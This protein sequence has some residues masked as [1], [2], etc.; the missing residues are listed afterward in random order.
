M[1]STYKDDHHQPLLDSTSPIPVQESH[2]VFHLRGDR[3]LRINKLT[4]N[5]FLTIITVLTSV[6]MNVTLPLYSNSMTKDGGSE[7]P[8]LLLS[9]M[10]FPFFFFGLVFL[11][12]FLSPSMSLRSSVSNRIMLLVG[13]LNAINGVLVVYASSTSRTPA[14]LQ[15]ILSTSVI[16]FTVI[17][18]Y[19]LLR[20]G[21]SKARLVCTG[22]V[23]IGL[24]I[25]LEP[26]IFN[27]DGNGG[28]G[29]GGE[30]LSNFEK[31]IWPVIFMF[32][33]LPVGI[34]NAVLERELKKGE[35]ESLLFLAWA[36]LYNFVFIAALF[37]TD[38][39]PRF[40]ASSSFHDFW[41][42]LTYGLKCQYGADQ[43]CHSA[44]GASWIFIL[45]YCSANLMIFLLVKY[46]E[47]AIYLVVV[48]AMVTPLGALF[49][50]F[51]VPTPYFHWDPHFLQL[52]TFFIMLGILIMVPAVAMYNYFGMKEEKDLKRQLDLQS[53]DD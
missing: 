53:E 52:S 44:V 41:E 35:T 18:R 40:G 16:P 22:I 47:G 17:S 30:H 50:T 27:I 15:A 3:I 45:G 13:F 4:W 31:F 37:W 28:G 5:V 25:S 10:W 49:W 12:K 20:K 42:N 48:Q 33:F 24:F 2:Q 26:T 8:V 29:G 46:A 38:F 11:T 14:A 6:L 34:S 23:L 51:F 32:G 9:S 7:Y 43:S 39:I 19:I 36:Q 21:V 1:G